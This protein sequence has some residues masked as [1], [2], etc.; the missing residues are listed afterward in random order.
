M[1]DP[2]FLAIMRK[3][4]LALANSSSTPITI[5]SRLEQPPNPVPPHQRETQQTFHVGAP[6]L[7]KRHE[8][9]MNTNTPKEEHRR[10]F[11]MDY[12]NN[13]DKNQ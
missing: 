8:V 10:W 6:P 5:S 11:F 4:D 3:P 2:V 9:L 13:N 1:P 12:L 7:D